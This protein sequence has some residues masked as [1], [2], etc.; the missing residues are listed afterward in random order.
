MT[1]RKVGLFGCLKVRGTRPT[2]RGEP[3]PLTVHALYPPRDGDRFAFVVVIRHS[4]V[5]SAAAAFAAAVA[6]GGAHVPVAVSSPVMSPLNVTTPR[7]LPGHSSITNDGKLEMRPPVSVPFDVL[8]SPVGKCCVKIATP[9]D[10]SV[11]GRR[12]QAEREK[13]RRRHNKTCQHE[14]RTTN[15]SGNRHTAARSHSGWGHFRGRYPR[16]SN[17]SSLGA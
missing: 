9:L 7:G 14:M 10:A 15:A 8:T 17:S 12:S 1:M 3:P 16:G 4:P 13:G 2:C 11:T 5:G 6:V